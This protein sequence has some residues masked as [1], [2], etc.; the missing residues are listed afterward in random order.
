MVLDM[1]M[2]AMLLVGPLHVQLFNVACQALVGP[3]YPIELGMPLESSSPKLWL[4]NCAAFDDVMYQGRTLLEYAPA[5]GDEGTEAVA[6][7]AESYSPVRD[8][9][10]TTR[11]VLWVMPHLQAR[12]DSAR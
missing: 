12:R 11:A 3:L 8:D 2:A 5:A 1:R 9:T 10:G 4:R 7:V 6:G